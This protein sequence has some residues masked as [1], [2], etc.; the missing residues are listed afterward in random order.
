MLALIAWCEQK[1][2]VARTLN[3]CQSNR[4]HPI[5]PPGTIPF[6]NYFGWLFCGF[7]GQD[8]IAGLKCLRVS[9]SVY[10]CEF[11]EVSTLLNFSN[12]RDTGIDAWVEMA[13]S[14]SE[15]VLLNSELWWVSRCTLHMLK[16]ALSVHVFPG[17]PCIEFRPR[18]WAPSSY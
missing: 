9:P 5:N 16:R 8:L 17:L 10:W 1:S 6:K 14:T 18:N 7:S 2:L 11:W 13:S 15:V 12:K 4:C 3:V